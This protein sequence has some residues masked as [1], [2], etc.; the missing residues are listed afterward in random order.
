LIKVDPLIK[1]EIVKTLVKDRNSKRIK[2]M[3]IILIII[4]KLIELLRTKISKEEGQF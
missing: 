1:K 3:A 2:T 4:I